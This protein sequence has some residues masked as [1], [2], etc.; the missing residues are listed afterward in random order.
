MTATFACQA[1]TMTT[2]EN[3]T[4]AGGWVPLAREAFEQGMVPWIGQKYVP[5]LRACTRA[6]PVDLQGLGLIKP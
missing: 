6:H 2:A 3:S 1:R 5:W 4:V